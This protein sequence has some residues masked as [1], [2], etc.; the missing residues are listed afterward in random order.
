MS[1]AGGRLYRIVKWDENFENNRSRELKELAW[2]PVP[3]RHDGSGYLELVDHPD[4]AAHFGAWVLIVE[5]ASK[6][7]PRGTLLRSSGKPHDARSLAMMTRIP[8]AVFTAVLPRLLDIGWLELVPQE[9]AT[10]SQEGATISQEGATISQEGA[11]I[12][13]EGATISQE[14]AIPSMNGIEKKGKEENLSNEAKRQANFKELLTNH[15]AR[16]IFEKLWGAAFE[17]HAEARRWAPLVASVAQEIEAN[18]LPRDRV[19]AAATD[20]ACDAAAGRLKKG[21]GPVF[22]GCIKKMRDNGSERRK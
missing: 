5:V 3:N 8:E 1:E 9:G 22:A 12:S 17:E 10:I 20:V 6:C 2:V 15:N 21:I 14:G 4:G 11:T 19:L 7:S 13:Q 16:A 18:L